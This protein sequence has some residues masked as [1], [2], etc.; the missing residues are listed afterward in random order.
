MSCEWVAFTSIFPW[1]TSTHTP[2]K[3]LEMVFQIT[4]YLA[5]L[6]SCPAQPTL[7]ST[8]LEKE[9]ENIRTSLSI[10]MLN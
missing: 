9:R 6:L 10:L 1:K 2:W 4:P 5:S 3:G 7:N 8:I